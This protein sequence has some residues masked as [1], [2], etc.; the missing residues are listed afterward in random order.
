MA[1][2]LQKSIGQDIA[3]SRGDI[4]KRTQARDFI[5]GEL[6]YDYI[7]KDL[8]IG[9]GRSNPNI[10]MSIGGLN[11]IRWQGDW[12]QTYLPDES[13]KVLPGYIYRCTKTIAASDRLE[14]ILPNDLIL[15]YEPKNKNSTS[16]LPEG[17]V[18]G[19]GGWVRINQTKAEAKNV[20]FN[21]ISLTDI[22]RAADSLQKAVS[23]LDRF[24][25]G[26][27]G[28]IASPDPTKLD[29]LLD[30][31]ECGKLYCA[32]NDF[33]IYRTDEV[34]LNIFT[35][36]GSEE[37]LKPD[38]QPLEEPGKVK[39]SKDEIL[40]VVL[41]PNISEREDLDGNEIRSGLYSA[42][43]KE[44]LTTKKLDNGLYG[45]NFELTI[46]F[47]LDVVE[48]FKYRGIFIDNGIEVVKE[49]EIPSPGKYSFYSTFNSPEVTFDRLEVSADFINE[50]ET[51]Q[52]SPDLNLKLYGVNMIYHSGTQDTKVAD[53]KK[54]DLL[55]C[56]YKIPEGYTGGNNYE[57]E[58]SLEEVKREF[59]ELKVFPVGVPLASN[60]SYSVVKSR[61]STMASNDYG[62]SDRKEI[63]NVKD[64]LDKIW[65]TKADLDSE[66]RVYLDQLPAFL[67]H[68]LHYMGLWDNKLTNSSWNPPSLTY[69]NNIDP[70]VDR[71]FFWLWTGLNYEYKDQDGKEHIIRPGDMLI[72]NSTITSGDIPGWEVYHRSDQVESEMGI[73]TESSTEEILRGVV[74]F[75]G[76]V[77]PTGTVETRVEHNGE[78]VYF[79]APNSMLTETTS[80]REGVIYKEKAPGTKEFVESSIQELQDDIRF[81]KDLT[82]LD[83]EGN[84]VTIKAGSLDSG[85]LKNFIINMPT[86]SGTLI[87]REQV[88][89]EFSRPNP[90]DNF[91][92]KAYTDENGWKKFADSKVR[93]IENGVAF[94][95]NRAEDGSVLAEVQF[96][97]DRKVSSNKNITLY[98]PDHN[99]V[100][101]NSR[102]I[103]DC[104][105]WDLDVIASLEAGTEEKIDEQAVK[106]TYE[107]NREA[108][109]ALETN[110]NESLAALR[111]KSV[112]KFT[113]TTAVDL[114]FTAGSY[115]TVFDLWK[116]ID[117][118]CPGADAGIISFQWYDSKAAYINK[119]GSSSDANTCQLNGG[120]LIFSK[121]ADYTPEWNQFRALYIPGGSK[122]DMYTLRAYCTDTQQNQIIS[123]IP[124]TIENVNL[125]ITDNV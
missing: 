108:I 22:P 34:I 59:K 74:K 46:D 15:Y 13:L 33:S 121:Q 24:K 103:I 58:Y 43:I 48:D 39:V 57:I 29:D 20:S 47:S 96:D 115:N 84:K 19:E 41:R 92:P 12:D 109:K 61:P 62:I 68:G 26:W 21:T 40:E 2:Q 88:E 105:T 125:W 14:E 50:D 116:K 79:I 67:F 51:V 27:G 77:R 85:V 45:K 5:S 75:K 36:F 97:M 114:G 3:I 17:S 69:P 113:N 28:E 123:V 55:Y 89:T 63:S 35:P 16:E 53:I 30:R 78:A 32:L 98:I 95:K 76:V 31:L 9:G 52:T 101:L 44:I 10:P 87:T 49:L 100:M 82:L 42:P 66:N 7:T 38:L 18:N 54:T 118:I 11:S 6:F 90:T 111:K 71:G 81:E 112:K 117:A 122:I 94:V 64:A 37:L 102:S 65:L 91:L 70:K 107:I 4:S 110:T 60:I 104:Y 23:F 120:V 124:D 25:L 83:F 119:S 99:G 8:W 86:A 106:G 73:M 93:D 1:Q 72:S 56:T 80:L